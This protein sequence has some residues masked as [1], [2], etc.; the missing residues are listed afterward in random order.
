MFLHVHMMYVPPNRKWMQ[1]TC[2]LYYR[3]SEI[4]YKLSYWISNHNDKSRSWVINGN[5]TDQKWA[6]IHKNSKFIV[7]KLTL[8]GQNRNS[9]IIHVLMHK[10]TKTPTAATIPFHV[11]YYINH[12]PK[13]FPGKIDLWKLTFGFD[14]YI[15]T[16]DLFHSTN[17]N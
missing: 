1:D 10:E 15:P 5:P 9:L 12:S 13:H 6:S 14:P 3:D 17:W 2:T 7:I 8:M 4:Q 16:S 11:H